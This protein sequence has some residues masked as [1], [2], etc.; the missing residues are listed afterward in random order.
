MTRASTASLLLLLLLQMVSPAY[1]EDA[2]GNVERAPAELVANADLKLPNLGDAMSRNDNYV[3]DAGSGGR[4]LIHIGR[5][6][7]TGEDTGD[8]V[9]V[10]GLSGDVPN[11]LL[12][13]PLEDSKITVVGD[14]ARITGRHV[15]SLCDSCD[16]WE[17]A[18]EGDVF[19][20]PM[21]IYLPS[22]NKKALLSKEDASKLMADIQAAAEREKTHQARYSGNRYAEY[23][24]ARV[25]EACVL[26][27]LCDQTK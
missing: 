1:A 19:F 14:Q 26:L 20:I 12:Q 8:I 17:A 5:Y 18:P 3:A 13:F 25:K 6:G 7:G 2:P 4:W 27:L 15:I 23:A 9:M 22:L 16:G 11:R 21:D 24:D 10:F